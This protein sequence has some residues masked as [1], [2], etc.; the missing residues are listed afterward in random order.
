MVRS[1]G[2]TTL[3]AD[4]RPSLSDFWERGPDAAE[5]IDPEADSS[6][7]LSPKPN[8]PADLMWMMAE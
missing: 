7:K 8:V 6:S 2:P 1:A 5:W 3:D 4:A